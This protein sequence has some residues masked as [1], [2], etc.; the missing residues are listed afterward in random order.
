MAGPPTHSSIGQANN[1]AVRIRGASKDYNTGGLLP[2]EED[3][4]KLAM[5]PTSKN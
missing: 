1:L 4:V 3:P 2:I 5:P